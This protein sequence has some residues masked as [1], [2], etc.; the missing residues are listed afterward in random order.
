LAKP[1]SATQE[2]GITSWD[3]LIAKMEANKPDGGYS[4]LVLSGHGSGGGVATLGGALNARS[5]TPAQADKLKAML[6]DG[7]PVIVF[8][9][10]QG[11]NALCQDLANAVSHPV[12]GNTG[13][14]N[15]GNSG[16]GH[17]VR[18]NPPK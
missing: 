7:A 13:D 5:L 3:D 8:A 9:C 15:K 6:K 10:K 16:E 14:V 1:S 17:W 2:S 4:A 12:I 11:A 18:F